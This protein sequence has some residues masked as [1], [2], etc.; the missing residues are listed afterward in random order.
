MSTNPD[1]TIEGVQKWITACRGGPD[2]TASLPKILGFR[3]LENLQDNYLAVVAIQLE[4]KKFVTWIWN[5]TIMAMVEGHYF[6]V[7]AGCPL[8]MAHAECMECFRVHRRLR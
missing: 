2:S 6:D 1:A 5:Q 4:E 8:V 7:D 3:R